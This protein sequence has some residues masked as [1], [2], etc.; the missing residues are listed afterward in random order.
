MLKNYEQRGL[1][2]QSTSMI[3]RLLFALSSYCVLSISNGNASS[4]VDSGVDPN[5][6]LGSYRS[7]QPPFGACSGF[8]VCELGFFCLD[9]IRSPCP[10]GYFGDSQRLDSITCS[11]QCNAG[12]YCSAGSITRTS[13][14]CGR[15]DVFCPIGS[16]VPVEVP[17]GY[18]SVDIDNS[19]SSRTVS[20]RVLSVICP[21][22]YYCESGLKHPCAGGKYGLT[23]GLNSSECSGTCPEGEAAGN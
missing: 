1:C 20:L 11:G 8:K 10:A 18:Y 19:D 5:C 4:A 15:S 3:V 22:G 21:E 17:L 12:Y 6:M 7:T 23:Q 16:A 2:W 13:N 9:G 14:P